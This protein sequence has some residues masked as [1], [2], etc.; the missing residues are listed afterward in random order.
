VKISIQRAQA[1][2]QK[3]DVLVIAH[4]ALPEPT[5]N[6]K[7]AKRPAALDELDDATDGALWKAAGAE[8]FSFA[9]DTTFSF[10]THGLVG[11]RR[12]VLLGLGAAEDLGVDQFRTA[13]GRAW[14]ACRTHDAK[15]VLQ[16]PAIDAVSASNAAEAA[17]EG[18]L[19]ASYKF[20]RYLSEEPA[21]EG[22]TWARVIHPDVP[23][24]A[25]HLIARAE[26]VAEGVSLARDLVNEPPRTLSPEHFAAE[27]K[28]VGKET[29]LTINVLTEKELKKERMELMLAVSAAASPYRPPR[30]VRM[31]YRPKGKKPRKHI[32]LV[33]KGLVFDSGGLD[34][35]PAAGM[36]EMKIDMGGAAAVI[37]TMLT[38]G[39]LAP[40]DVAVTGYLG[41]VENGIGGNAYHPSDIIKSRKGLT[42][43][44]NNTDAEGRL[45]LADC[46]DYAIEKDSPDVLIDLAT[47]TGACMVALGPSTAGLFSD[48]DDLAQDIR[49]NGERAGESFWRLPLNK[50][51]GYQ[52][53]SPIAD[54]KNTGE[55][56]GGAITAGLFLQKFVDDRAR[57]AHLDIAGPCTEDRDHAYTPRGGAGFGVRTLVGLIAPYA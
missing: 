48:D 12:V 16:L 30:M 39:R 25:D 33:G 38:I 21:S 24:K 28:R 13:G 51:L 35:K 27:A 20:D 53:K 29:G 17:V 56:F 47:L 45:V 40:D 19:L 41:C 55:R 9:A 7:K 32:V 42:V 52:L 44:V 43:E 2:T 54:T 37:G 50:A 46:I 49:N 1:L 57:W 23:K 26:A 15:V 6:R 31:A 4:P 11:A 36:L 22:V 34:I 14:R 5:G 10:D 18:L 8:Q 3:V